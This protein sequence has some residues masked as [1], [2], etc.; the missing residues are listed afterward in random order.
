MDYQGSTS[1]PD[2]SFRPIWPSNDGAVRHIV[3]WTSVI[4]ASLIVVA[5]RY[6]LADELYRT[7]RIESKY[8]Q[9][10]LSSR[11]LGN[12]L[13]SHKDRGGCDEVEVMNSFENA[14]GLVPDRVI[15][16]KLF[17]RLISR[18]NSG[19][20]R[21]LIDKISGGFYCDEMM[22]IHRFRHSY[23]SGLHRSN[24]HH[25]AIAGATQACHQS[26]TS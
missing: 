5:E 26:Q 19:R 20:R 9:I 23:N 25:A 7:W 17:S 14:R 13:L 16:S 22:F 4:L 8:V 21:I 3:V 10:H 15:W 18:R 12:C 1:H 24:H 11:L 6:I 2:D